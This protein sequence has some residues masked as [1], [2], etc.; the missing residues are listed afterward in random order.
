MKN[1]INKFILGG[2]YFFKHEDNRMKDEGDVVSARKIFL[3]SRFNNLDFMLKKRFNWMN[4]YLNDKKNI[5]E[6]GS[7]AGFSRIYIDSPYVMTDVLNSEWIDLN[8]DALNLDLS[9]DSCD[10]IITSHCI[11]HFAKPVIF[12]KEC[13]RV[14][15]PGGLI[16]IQ[17]IN[18]S[19]MM[20]F[21]LR[22]MRHEGWSYDVDVFDEKNAVNHKDDPWS[23]NCAVPELLFNNVNMFHKKFPFLEVVSDLKN[24]GFILP[25]SGGVISKVKMIELPN[26]FLEIVNFI[27]KVLI[28]IAPNI[29]A[30]GRSVIIKKKS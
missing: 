4:P 7:G 16:L 10:A 3:K 2:T 6:L 5:Y 18:T 21:F 13:E 14:L 26:W 30:M 24:E 23:A 22:L 27:D 12:F 19:L 28:S 17:E 15:K 1:T 9:D 29:F 8:L 25:L 20:R 11:H